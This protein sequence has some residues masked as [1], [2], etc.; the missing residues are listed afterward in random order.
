MSVK[1]V[2]GSDTPCLQSQ[3]VDLTVSVIAIEQSALFSA[4]A[5]YYIV[6]VHKAVDSTAPELSLM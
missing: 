4:M 2:P 1:R 5:M 3:Y 6:L